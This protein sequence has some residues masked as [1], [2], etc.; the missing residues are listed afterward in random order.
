MIGSCRGGCMLSIPAWREFQCMAQDLCGLCVGAM[1][2]ST[3]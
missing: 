2:I 3:D 1:G